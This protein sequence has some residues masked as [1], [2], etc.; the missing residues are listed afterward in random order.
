MQRTG[1]TEGTLIYNEWLKKHNLYREDTELNFINWLYSTSGYYDTQVDGTFFNFTPEARTTLYEKWLHT[2]P[3]LI[4]DSDLSHIMVHDDYWVDQTHL[5]EFLSEFPP[6]YCYWKDMGYLKNSLTGRVLVVNYFAPLIAEKYD[7]YAYQ[8]PLT[9]RNS[10][11]DKNF[12]ETLDRM[13][14]EIPK[15][16]DTYL[17]SCGAYGSFL[18]PHFTNSI[19]VGSGLHDLYPVEIPDS[20]KP[21]WFMDIED[22]RYWLPGV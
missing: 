7:V 21:S 11:P 8:T 9:M 17:I 13:I 3:G 16:Y 12:F 1:L 14:E 22:G 15:D 5:P 4:K 20:Y 2:L 19:V 10:G 6:Q 18:A